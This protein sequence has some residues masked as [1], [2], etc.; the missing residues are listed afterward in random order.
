M[1]WHP[2]QQHVPQS[3]VHREPVEGGGID[4]AGGAVVK[5][6]GADVVAG[7]AEVVAGGADV[8][9]GA[10]EVVAG[11]ADAELK[12]STTLESMPL[13]AARGMRLAHANQQ[14]NPRTLS[15]PIPQPAQHNTHRCENKHGNTY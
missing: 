13:P 5:G 6:L 15:H 7:A 1:A 9:A 8:V 3:L 11:G 14:S 4:V 2:G 12:M 10:A